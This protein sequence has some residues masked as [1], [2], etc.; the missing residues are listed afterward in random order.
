MYEKGLYTFMFSVHCVK[1]FTSKL[2]VPGTSI[3]MRTNTY[4]NDGSVF[5]QKFDSPRAFLMTLS[6][7]PKFGSFTPRVW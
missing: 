4:A 7:R 6:L 2:G 5:E 3:Y 1:T